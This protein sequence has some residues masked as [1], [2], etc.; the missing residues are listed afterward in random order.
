[1]SSSLM[2]SFGVKYRQ[3]ILLLLKLEP[4]R[5]TFMLNYLLDVDRT[6]FVDDCFRCRKYNGKL[7]YV[8]K[9]LN[10]FVDM[11]DKLFLSK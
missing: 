4:T 1:M 5:M 2:P 10:L 3:Q 6:E 8:I 7:E 9:W 11:Y